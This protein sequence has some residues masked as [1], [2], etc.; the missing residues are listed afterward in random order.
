VSIARFSP[1]IE[2][3]T[4]H[5]STRLSP[6][7]IAEIED[8]ITVTDF[9]AIEAASRG[10]SMTDLEQ[11]SLTVQHGNGVSRLDAPLLS[12]HYFQQRKLL[13]VP[14]LDLSAA[15]RLWHALDAV[16]PYR[17]HSEVV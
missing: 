3:G 8:L 13:P 5:L 15:L 16:S 2:R 12:W 14:E 10:F 4:K 1:R 6:A 11:C 17:N 9:S 7:Q